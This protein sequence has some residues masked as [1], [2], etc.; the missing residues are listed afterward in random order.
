MTSLSRPR[1][2]NCRVKQ[3]NN[4]CRVV[5]GGPQKPLQEKHECL[6]FQD[7]DVCM[8]F[9]AN[10]EDVGKVLKLQFVRIMAK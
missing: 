7:V 8:K 9:G 1:P 3:N 4:S 2:E 5:L 10:T 6:T